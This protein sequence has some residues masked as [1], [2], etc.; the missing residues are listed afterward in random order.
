M[1]EP[2]EINFYKCHGGGGQPTGAKG[3]AAAGKGAGR[4][5]VFCCC[6]QSVISLMKWPITRAK[7]PGRAVLG[8]IGMDAVASG[9]SGWIPYIHF[10]SEI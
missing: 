2:T 7:P 3:N 5:P 6:V 9:S 1:E 8:S 10:I 4:G